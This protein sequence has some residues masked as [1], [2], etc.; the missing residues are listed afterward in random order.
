MSNI[1]LTN[2]A[3]NFE[4]KTPKQPKDLSDYERSVAILYKDIKFDLTN[5][6]ETG[7][8]TDN[9]INSNISSKDIEVS[10]NEEAIINSLK[11]WFRT[12]QYS[13]LLNPELR[14]DLK[15]YLFEGVDS[16]SAYF[17]GLDL[18]EKL[19]YYESRIKV[20]DCTIEVDTE[21]DR[22]IIE[23]LIS[24]PSLNNKIINLKEVLDASGYTNL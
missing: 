9:S 24:V 4:D 19:P 10:I 20:E 22:F 8:F 3:K 1:K 2:L 18:M 6:N 11:N 23:L 21:N 7:I 13:R 12:T 15:E 17:L 5:I 14:L 16:Y